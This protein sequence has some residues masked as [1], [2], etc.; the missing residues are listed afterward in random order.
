MLQSWTR[1]E[2]TD[3]NYFIRGIKDRSGLVCVPQKLVYY[4]PKGMAQIPRGGL[5][6]GLSQF[7]D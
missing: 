2:N 7:H 1:Y 4:C 6:F 5:T 3:N